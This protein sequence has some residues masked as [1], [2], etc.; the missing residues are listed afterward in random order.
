M[1]DLATAFSVCLNNIRIMIASMFENQTILF[2]IAVPFAI[3]FLG[4]LFSVFRK[5]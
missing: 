4:L 1:A 2:L 3:G 5:S